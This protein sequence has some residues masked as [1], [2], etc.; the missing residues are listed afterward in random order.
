[1]PDILSIRGHKYVFYRDVEYDF[2]K[3]GLTVIRGLNKDANAGATNGSGKTLVFN[4]LKDIILDESESGQGSKTA[5]DEPYIGLVV[6][7]ENGN[8]YDVTKYLGKK[9]FKFTKN[10]KDTKE[11]GLDY[12]NQ[13]IRSITGITDEEEFYSLYFLDSGQHRLQTAKSADRF[14]FFV[15]LFR[16][17]SADNLRKLLLAELREA[18]NAKAAL[19]EIRTTFNEMKA[20]A[21][22]AEVL[23][24]LTAEL[25]EKRI[26]QG[27][28][29]NRLTRSRKAYDLMRFEK[30]NAVQVE[31][32]LKISSPSTIVADITALKKSRAKLKDMNAVADEWRIF[33]KAIA[34]Y[35]KEVQP[36]M[37]R[38]RELKLNK[39][40]AA[41]GNAKFEAAAL[42]LEDAKAAFM[43]EIPELP[44]EETLT[45]DKVQLRL[46]A[47][48]EELSH[49]K[50]IKG[51]I[52]SNCGQPYK[53]ERTRTEV[54]ELIQRGEQ[55]LATLQKNETIRQQHTDKNVAKEL[56]LKL[57]WQKA[58]YADAHEAHTL[59]ASLPKR[60][61]EPTEERPTVTDVEDKI[62]RYTQRIDF[63]EV[64]LPLAPMIEQLQA[65]T[66]EERALSEGVD[67][68]TSK[69]AH[70]TEE[71]A[72]LQSRV[73][74]AEQAHKQLKSLRRRG[75]ALKE[76]A[77]EEPVLKAMTKV[78]SNKYIIK[79]MVERYAKAVERQI[80]KFRKLLFSEDFTFTFEV[81]TKFNIW[82]SRKYDKRTVVS[83]VRKLSGAESTFFGLLLLVSLLSL[84]PK[85]RRLN[86]LV[87]D[88]PTARMGDEAR[89]AFS[90]FLPILN[91]V[92]PHIVVITPRED[93]NYEGARVFR[94]VKSKGISKLEVVTA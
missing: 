50:N 52:C 84:V 48:R 28:I 4:I 10:E 61:K 30:T 2:S 39:D 16:L 47:W 94:A 75:L 55:R 43:V 44:P 37:Q 32:F 60:P 68:L 90:R 76:I 81:E 34:A 69:Y 20:G 72:T 71:L 87:L 91:K 22:S 78:Y 54:E 93:E 42:R 67:E 36:T 31:R 92:I 14:R 88:E 38:L 73:N 35:G 7:T 51:G 79:L 29:S 64:T 18:Q 89:E 19:A 63:L 15:N 57:K 41:E 1:M 17:H 80:N 8:V 21:V 46:A 77:E 56:Y 70:L 11:R 25:D 65:L 49:L 13:I 66:P 3:P 83:D 59:W 40:E 53:S 24:T 62:A 12:G 5:K 33:D 9:R 26:R 23:A 86:F 82:V 58:K 6:Q 74:T 45:V 27:K 85:R